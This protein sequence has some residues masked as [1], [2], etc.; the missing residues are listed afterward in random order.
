MNARDAARIFWDV[1]RFLEVRNPE[2]LPTFTPLFEEKI[3]AMAEFAN[4]H[5]PHPEGFLG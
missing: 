3:Q 2:L 4:E 1:R 5:F